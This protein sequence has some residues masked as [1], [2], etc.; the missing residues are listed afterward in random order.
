MIQKQYK[1]LLTNNLK[2][3]LFTFSKYVMYNLGIHSAVYYLVLPN[4]ATCS[5]A[6]G[7]N[8]IW[9]FSNIQI[10]IKNINTIITYNLLYY[11]I[12]KKHSITLFNNNT[13]QN[14]TIDDVLTNQTP[15][16]NG[17][18]IDFL[19]NNNIT[20]HIFLFKY[21]LLLSY[22]KCS[23]KFLSGCI[24]LYGKEYIIHLSSETEDYFITNNRLNKYTLSYILFKQH[25]I[26]IESYDNFTFNIIDQNVNFKSITNTEEIVLGKDSYQIV[27]YEP[28]I[29]DDDDDDTLS[30]MSSD[31]DNDDAENESE[32]K[33]KNNSEEP[34]N[35]SNTEDDAGYD[36]CKYS[37]NTILVSKET[38][39][40]LHI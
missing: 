13:T 28:Q 3:D 16:K 25:H 36:D 38:I 33:D 27:S 19:I 11:N 34:V 1:D 18:F 29:I 32:S 21:S 37:L 5:Y 10:F 15:L 35:D 20:S 26:Y 7:Y 31:D 22:E 6:I 30:E 39:T 23:Y 14:L 2:M 24:C 4:I 17:M 8:L 40:P 9:G 12:I